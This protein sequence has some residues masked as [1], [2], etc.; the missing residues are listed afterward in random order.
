MTQ[1]EQI[2]KRLLPDTDRELADFIALFRAGRC[3]Q[4]NL[5]WN[6]IFALQSKS[7]RPFTI[8][9]PYLRFRSAEPTPR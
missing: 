6:S 1:M 9:A 4:A 3:R 8:T 2:Q 7:R 5:V